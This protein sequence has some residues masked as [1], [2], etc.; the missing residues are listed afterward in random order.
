MNQRL[1]QYLASIWLLTVMTALGWLLMTAVHELGHV[2]G[3]WLSGGRV[4]S[5]QLEPFAFSLTIV[6]PNPHPQFVAWC[7]PMGGAA[8]PAIAYIIFK[9]LRWK[10][11]WLLRFFAGFCLIANGAYLGVGW[12]GRI[13][14]AGDLLRYGAP[15]WS[16]CLFGA[17]GVGSG[18]WCWNGVGAKMGIGRKA[19]RPNWRLAT[20]LAVLWVILAMTAVYI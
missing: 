16:L 3:A 12:L 1:T 2:L 17:A 5:I 9:R 11:R 20:I 18:L 19:G 15:W 10:D 13:G 7:G 6:S 8:I 14:D 4:E